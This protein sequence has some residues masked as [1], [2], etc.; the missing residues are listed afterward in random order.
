MT[1]LVWRQFRVPALSVSAGVL[2]V[3]AVLAVTGPDLVGRTNFSDVETLY[4]GTLLA[5]Y[6]LPAVI[7]V[8]WGAPMV[9]RELETGTHS[10][11][12]NQS[13]TR[14]RWLATKFAV[15]V[16]AAMAAAGLLSLAVTWWAAPMDAAADLD[17]DR[18]ARIV[19]E[20]F[21]GRGV[22]PVGYAAFALLLGVAIGM[23]VRRTV[24]AMALTLVLFAAVQVL[25][26]LLVRPHLLPPTEESVVIT[27]ENVRQVGG[28]EHGVIDFMTVAP[29]DGAWVLTNETVDASGKAV[30]PLPG[31]VQ[32]CVPKPGSGAFPER[33]SITSC[34][35]RLTDLGYRQHLV[36]QPGSRF[37]PLQWLELALFLA[38]SALLGWFCFR[39]LRHLS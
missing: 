18:L 32:D 11:V 5:V 38:L 23:V 35:A 4:T 34:M 12:W 25:V 24:P 27:A 31:S 16:P 29:P 15:G 37:W 22:A 33:G 30:R 8:F 6:V 10:L 20:V 1:W 26:P 21:A 9:T 13:V 19:P 7:G 3:A 39:R 17:D 36:Y 28:D 2:V 14:T